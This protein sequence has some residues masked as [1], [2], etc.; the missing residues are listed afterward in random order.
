MSATRVRARRAR[1]GSPCRSR[2]PSSAS[3]GRCAGAAAPARRRR[4]ARRSAAR[5]VRRVD[6]VALRR[7]GEVDRR[8]RE[9]GVPLGHADEVHGLLGGHGDRERL[10]DRRCRRPRRRSARGGARRRAGPRRPRASAPASRRPRRG[11]SCASTCAAPRSGCSAPRPPCRRAARGAGSPAA[12]RGDVDAPH[13]VAAAAPPA[14]AQLEHVERGARVAVGEARDRV[15]RVRRRRRR[16]RA[17][18]PRSASASA[19]REDADDVRR[20]RAAQHEHLRAREERRVHLERRVLG[21]RADQDDVARLDVRQERVLLRLVE[22]VDLVDEEDR[23][24]ARRR[25]RS[26]SASA[27][28]VA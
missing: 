12:T 21:R 16:P 28:T 17:P 18:R 1:S 5:L 7:G 25:A 6:G 2:A 11:R 3:S 10:R 14:T 8:L 27:M 24:A 4:G 20:R 15:E 23:A 19:R 13:A 22:A 26:R 9:R